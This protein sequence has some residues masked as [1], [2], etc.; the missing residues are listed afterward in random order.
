MHRFSGRWICLI[1][2]LLVVG[3]VARADDEI[4]SSR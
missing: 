4:D 2:G 1:V 3:A